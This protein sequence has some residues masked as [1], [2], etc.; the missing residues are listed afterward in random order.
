M[1]LSYALPEGAAACWR[2]RCPRRSNTAPYCKQRDTSSASGSGTLDDD[3]ICRNYFAAL[4][5]EHAPRCLESVN[6][7]AGRVDNLKGCIYRILLNRPY[8]FQIAVYPPR[9][10]AMFKVY[11]CIANAHDLRLVGLAA[12]VCILASFA[13]VNLLHHARKSTGRMRPMWLGISAIS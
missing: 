8:C 5:E 7:L 11:N 9:G 4:R 13:A 12:L 3:G 1:W 10:I 6:T 2:H